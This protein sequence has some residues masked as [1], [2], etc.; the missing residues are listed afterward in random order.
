MF[1]TGAALWF[2]FIGYEWK[3]AKYPIM[4]K[5]VLN[6]SLICSCVIDFVRRFPHTCQLATSLSWVKYTKIT[7]LLLVVLCRGH[8][9][10]LVGLRRQ[11]LGHKII[12]HVL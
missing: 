6:R 10:A 9:L 8:L 2:V 4:P 1:A 11:G 7:V 5:R 3:F 12:H